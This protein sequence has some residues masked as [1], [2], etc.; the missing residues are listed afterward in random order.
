M[1]DRR[2]VMLI[3][4]LVVVIVAALVGVGAL[5]SGRAIAGAARTGVDRSEART[6]A[7]AGVRAIAEDLLEQRDELLAGEDAALD[8]EYELWESESVRAVAV[9]LPV[10]NDGDTLVSESAKLGLNTA[11]A[12]MLAGLDAIDEPLARGIVDARPQQGFASVDDLL[13]IDG[14]TPELLFGPRERWAGRW[15]DSDDGPVDYEPALADLLTVFGADPNVQSGLGEINANF[16]GELRVNLNRPWSDD[17][18]REL[19]DLFDD[20]DTVTTIRVLNAQGAFADEATFVRTLVRFGLPTD[21]VRWILDLFTTTPDPYLVGRVDTLRAPPEVL[22]CL[23]GATPESVQALVALRD[24]LSDE[25]RGSPTWCVREEGIPSGA[26]ERFAPFASVRSMQWRVRIRTGIATDNEGTDP[27]SRVPMRHERVTEVVFDLAGPRPRIAFLQDISAR[28]RVA[29]Q[30]E[31]AEREPRDGDASASLALSS[32][33]GS[34]PARD[35][36]AFGLSGRARTG[37]GQLER[38]GAADRVRGDPLDTDGAET[39]E[40]PPEGVDR[41][42]GRWTGGA[43]RGQM[44]DQEPGP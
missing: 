44:P 8:D 43:P 21:D 10:S 14:V 4:V 25:E 3:V 6:I 16:A 9:L 17:I 39:A 23:P 41:R 26:F 1:N 19:S 24:T 13:A 18:E 28:P 32:V 33:D 27:S 5:D 30:I 2:G 20:D 12:E 37:R 29:S 35:R 38:A 34:E 42:A 22:A 11:N 36:R 31:R 15:D 40:R 7:L